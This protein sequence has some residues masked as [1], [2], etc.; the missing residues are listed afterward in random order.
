MTQ[1]AKQEEAIGWSIRLRD[2]ATADWT[3]FT[4]WLEADPAHAAAYA[5]V[6]LADAD[7]VDALAPRAVADAAASVDQPDA[8]ND[9][10]PGFFRRYGSLAAAALVAV[11]AFPVWQIMTPTYSIETALGEQ[12]SVTLEDGTVIDLNGGTRITLDRRNPRLAMLDSGEARFRVTHDAARPF[13]V[14]AGDARIE[15]VGT[16][17]NVA[18][19]EGRTEV[20]VAE[21][22]VLY[23]P[24]REALLLKKGQRLHVAGA[25][26]APVVT[27]VDPAAVAGWKA[28]R[29]DFSEMRLGD[30][31][32]DLSRMIGAKVTVDPSIADRIF[33]GTIVIDRKDE[34]AI[35]KVAGM[36]GV[37]ARKAD[38]GWR[39]IAD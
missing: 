8:A 10:S 16:L 22:A 39:L 4:D 36:M 33:S 7:M 30:I 35:V 26:K 37:T 19:D 12:R 15:D 9:N 25:G 32:P 1:T 3:A 31:A 13:T 2:A 18:N 23:N 20:S 17:F 14:Q 11:A 21:G 24:K 38:Q 28:G 27:A 6:T 34:A 29:L 5:A